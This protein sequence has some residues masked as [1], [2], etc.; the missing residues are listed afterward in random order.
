MNEAMVQEMICKVLESCREGRFHPDLRLLYQMPWR[1]Q[2]PWLD[3]PN[4]ARPDD[5]TEGCH[6]G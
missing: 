5:L 4:W 1:E 6:E 3:F 2:V